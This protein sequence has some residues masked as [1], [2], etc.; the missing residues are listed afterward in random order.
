MDLDNRV[1]LVTGGGRGIG[2]AIALALARA[3]AHLTVCSRT[4]EEIKEV[5]AR[6]ESICSQSALAISVNVT[7]RP[8]I[9]DAVNQTVDRFGHLDVLVNNAGRTD[10]QHRNIENLPHQVWKKIIAVNLNGTFYS[11]QVVLPILYRQGEGNIINITSLLGQCGQACAGEPAYSASKFG[12]EGLSEV[13]AQEARPQGIN[14]NTLYPA[15]KVDTG[16]FDHLD[17]D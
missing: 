10:K 13:M 1:A 14:V 3:G 17:P 8:S 16:F 5:A 12:I 4:E 9:E 6:I 11:S 2:R 7:S 15:T